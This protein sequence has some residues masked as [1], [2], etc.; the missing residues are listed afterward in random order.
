M[1]FIHHPLN[2]IIQ[3]GDDCFLTELHGELCIVD[4]TIR[5]VDGSRVLLDMYGINDWGRVILRPERIITDDGLLLE[6]DLL[7]GVIIIGVV[8]LMIQKMW[9]DERPII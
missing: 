1:T 5:P 4:R 7:D 9:D 6:G 8:T 2:K 3:T